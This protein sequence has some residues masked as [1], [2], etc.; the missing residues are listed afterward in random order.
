MLKRVTSIFSCLCVLGTGSARAGESGPLLIKEFY[1]EAVA[2]VDHHMGDQYTMAMATARAP[3]RA[4]LSVLPASPLVSAGISSVSGPFVST[5][6][7]VS[8]PWMPDLPNL[9]AAA[10]IECRLRQASDPCWMV[11]GAGE[12]RHAGF[13][14][15]NAAGDM[16]ATG[17]SAQV[18]A[19]IDGFRAHGVTGSAGI[20]GHLYRAGDV[21][22]RT[23]QA[24]TEIRWNP[25]GAMLAGLAAKASPATKSPQVVLSF[26]GTW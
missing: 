25:A 4:T 7:H 3:V 20:G 24:I 9:Y 6:I 14:R 21:L 12:S 16:T 1:G 17:A 19:M 18:Q 13:L 22:T 23:P 15:F 26:G 10:R 8:T 2:I 11:S 5:G